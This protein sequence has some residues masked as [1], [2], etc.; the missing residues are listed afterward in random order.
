MSENNRKKVHDQI[1]ADVKEYMTNT[2]NSVLDFALA[3]AIKSGQNNLYDLCKKCKIPV[4][5]LLSKINTSLFKVDDDKI[6]LA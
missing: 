4:D 6:H 3:N 2:S 5:K 1:Q